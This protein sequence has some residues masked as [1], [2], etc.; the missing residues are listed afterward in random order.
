MPKFFGITFGLFILK[1][2]DNKNMDHTLYIV[3]T[4]NK[5]YVTNRQTHNEVRHD[6]GNVQS[7]VNPSKTS[8]TRMLW[9]KWAGLVGGP[10]QFFIYRKSGKLNE[11]EFDHY[12][13][14]HVHTHGYHGNHPPV[15]GL[16]ALSPVKAGL[17]YCSWLHS[18]MHLNTLTKHS[19]P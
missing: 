8:S 9:T 12:M 17:M 16:M 15:T 4:T 11:G 14:R 18:T 2:F 6:V 10:I 7:R 3:L 13:Q 5:C 1:Y 19:S